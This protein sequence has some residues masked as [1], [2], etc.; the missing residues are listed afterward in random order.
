MWTTWILLALLLFWAVGAY[1]RLIR[2]RSAAIQAFGGLDAHLQRW[3]SLL[4]EYRAARALPADGAAEP[5]AQDD[6][7]A[8]LWAATTQ[9]DASLTVARAKPLDAEAAA[10]LSA[11]AQVLETAWQTVVREAAQASEGVAPPA[12][13][14]WVQRREQVSL[15]GDVA[16]G[17]FNEAVRHY[18]H[19]V[20]Q[21]PA[22]L[23]AWLFGLKKGRPL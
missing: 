4:G 11:A 3:M 6:G 7:H 9:L 19:A 14:P 18:N 1:N 23:L 15:H 10:A 22:N 12:L 5:A 20:T 2:L 8:A 21:F 16:Q 17:R 13:A